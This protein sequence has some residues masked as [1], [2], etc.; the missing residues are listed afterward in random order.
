MFNRPKLIVGLDY[1]TYFD[2]KYS[3]RNKEMSTTEY[4]RHDL[5]KSQ[6][7]GIR[8]N[9]QKKAKWYPHDKI[10]AALAK[11]DWSET[12]VLCHHTAF[13][14]LILSH[15]YGIVPAYYYCSM[16]MAR[17]IFSHDIGV[18]L[19]EL[20]KHM[21]FEGKVKADAL[22]ATKGIRDLPKS[23]M[24]PLGAYCS[25]DVDDMWRMFRVMMNDYEF[26]DDELD[27]IHITINAY[28]NP[29]LNVDKPRVLKE[30]AR[31]K[32][33]SKHVIMGVAGPCGYSSADGTDEQIELIK[34]SLRSRKQ[35]PEIMRNNG[36]E[37]PTKISA[38]TGKET[39]AFAKTDL[40]FQALEF[41]R[42]KTIRDLYWAKLEANSSITVSR[43][44]RMLSH[45]KDGA[46]PIMLNYCRAHTMRWS[47]GDKLNPQNFPARGKN[48]N[49]LRKSIIAPPGYVIVVADSS[50]IEARKLGWVSGQE[51]LLEI[52]R[53]N[54][55]PYADLASEIYGRPI[56]KEHDKEE[57]DVGKVGILSLGFGAGWP[58][59]QLTLATGAM[60]PKV[61]ISE[62]LAKDSVKIYRRKNWA[63][64]NYWKHCQDMLYSMSNG[65][66]HDDGL[67]IFYPDKVLM[68]NGLY[69]HY[70]EMVCGG[71]DCTY[72]RGPGF[73]SKMYGALFTENIIQCLS[74][75]SVGEQILKIAERYR[76]VMM[77]HDEVSYLALESEAD[78]ALAYGIDCFRQAPEWCLDLPFDAD[79]G[80]DVCYSK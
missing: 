2:Q 23:L 4:I 78:E 34:T 73:Y 74:R 33:E 76:I 9:K 67:L 62:E 17:A 12:A 14:G 50:Q 13:D 77:T 36:E 39:Y 3:L 52:F 43:A 20:A 31:A 64:K 5:F 49:E 65:E 59:F 1:E 11:F 25:D 66:T 38:T 24:N 47:G 7:V 19:D 37:P 51:D 26:P 45:S 53:N 56:T 27:L 22:Q 16:S 63:I 41:H 21:G 15:H 42:N 46:L 29:I 68:P 75:I 69:L 10:E 18:G 55:D 6:C 44:T 80:Y 8:T 70:P 35:F 72:K 71:R 48:G 79:G 57:R 40:G 60:G 28:A 54:G 61:I 32:K 58:R 30:L